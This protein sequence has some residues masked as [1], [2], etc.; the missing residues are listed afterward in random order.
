MP[1]DR[2]LQRKTAVLSKLDKSSI[3][4]W[5]KKMKKL[6]EKI[7]SLEDFYTTSSCSGRVILMVQQEKKGKDLFLKIWHEKISFNELKRELN[8][9]IDKK[10][11]LSKKISLGLSVKSRVDRLT[12]SGKIIKFKLEPPIIHIA[13]RELKNATEMLEKAKY[14]GF[15][16][17]SILTFDRNIVLELNTSERLEFPII[18]DSKILVDDKFLKLIVEMSHQKLEGGWNKIQKLEKYF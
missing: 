7:N 6:C 14:V 15:K 17:S 18:K 12:I 2:F 4:E 1:R 10:I 16:R 8:N 13:C 3:G 9:L 11:V 5:D